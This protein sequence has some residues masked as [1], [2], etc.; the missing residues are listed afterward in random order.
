MSYYSMAHMYETVMG[1]YD[2]PKWRNRVL[3]MS[4]N[5]IMAIFYDY[6]EREEKKIVK[7]CGRNCGKSM[8]IDPDLG[9]N[10]GNVGT[11]TDEKAVFEP[12]QLS[13]FD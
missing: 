1:M 2:G 13:F 3:H 4:D 6:L 8:Q 11:C 9:K 5:Q 7:K 10:S 12:V